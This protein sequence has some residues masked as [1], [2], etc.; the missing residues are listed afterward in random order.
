[1]KRDP[2][3]SAFY[4]KLIDRYD[5]ADATREQQEATLQL[6]NLLIQAE[7]R[8]E[9]LLYVEAIDANGCYSISFL[10]FITKIDPSDSLLQK[11]IRL[12]IIKPKKRD[13]G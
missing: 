7:D 10:E 5:V 11:A 8:E 9:F 1:M 3:L 13:N 6:M 2:K 4:F 12:N